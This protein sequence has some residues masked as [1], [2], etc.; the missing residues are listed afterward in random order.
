MQVRQL[1]KNL[2][3]TAVHVSHSL[4]EV[5]GVAD[6][7]CVLNAGQIMQ[8][9]TPQELLKKPVNEFVALFTG[10]R[11]I[12]SGMVQRNCQ[13]MEFKAGNTRLYI[14]QKRE[15]AAQLV[16]RPEDIVLHCDEIDG[17]NTQQAKIMQVINQGALIKTHVQTEDQEWIVLTSRH[18]A[19]A[20]ELTE[21][22]KVY[23]QFPVDAIHVIY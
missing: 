15:G 8:V 3:T 20:F 1:L 13:G 6:R 11:N 22:L 14:A 21:G 4:D 17:L 12:I 7:I 2:G 19:E 5:F 16:I 10:C 18:E 23:L 9:A